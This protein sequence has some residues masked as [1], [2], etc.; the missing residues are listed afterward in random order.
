MN[1]IST[2][3][4]NLIPTSEDGILKGLFESLFFF[5]DFLKDVSV[6]KNVVRVVA[7]ILSFD[8]LEVIVE[9]ILLLG[10]GQCLL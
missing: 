8:F 6:E 7:F 9:E 4:G 10:S 3:A 5:I 1:K 2:A